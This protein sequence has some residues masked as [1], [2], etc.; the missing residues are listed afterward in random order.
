MS[1][2]FEKER[3]FADVGG[4]RM[5]YLDIGSGPAV[6]LGHSYLWSAE[7]WEPQIVAL[8]KH[9]RVIVPELW[10]HG[11][12]GALPD[13][14][15]T[16][17][18]VAQQ[19]LD[20]LD[21][22]GVERFVVAGLSVGGMWAVE[23]ALLIPDR[24]AGL[25]LL[26]TFVGSEPA[27]SRERYFSMLNTAESIGTVPDALIDAMLPMFFSTG[28]L[29]HRE[30]L[31]HGFRKRLR[32]VERGNL[33]ASVVPLGRMIFDR[34]DGLADLQKLKMPSLVITGEED[35]SRPPAEGRA[36]AAILGCKFVE[37][38]G[39]GH[40]S[41]LEAPNEVTERLLAFV[42]DAFERGQ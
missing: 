26:G 37:L 19:H 30:D 10:G 35:R 36:M 9:C 23:L 21:L 33:L 17:Q 27:Q 2:D 28:S 34:R 29:A 22:L 40:I 4:S 3:K 41:S 11:K 24:I 38:A 12:S 18:Q 25:V 39:V 8:S 20:L 1:L 31:I 14:T 42:G 6:V 7:M 32:D 16:L 13:N 5:S 15:L